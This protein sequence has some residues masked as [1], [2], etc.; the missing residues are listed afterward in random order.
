MLALVPA[1]P[2]VEWPLPLRT[3]LITAFVVPLMTF[4]LIP[5]LSRLLAGWLYCDHR[6][7]LNIVRL[8]DPPPSSRTHSGG[9]NE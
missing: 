9:G 3:L 7:S 2:I 1:T 8:T 4:V 5:T 6:T